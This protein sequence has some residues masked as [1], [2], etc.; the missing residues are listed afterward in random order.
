M[1]N[2]YW[3]GGAGTWDTTT[4]THWSASS[5]GASGA[6]VPTAADSVF[7]D[8]AGTYTV[9]CTGALT[10][11]DF[12][13][14]AG[15][16]TFTNG[17]APTF[18]V[19]GSMSLI[20]GT[21][22]TSTGAIT[23]NST[24]TGKTVTTNGVSLNSAINFNG[25]G[26]GW[27]LGSA[28]TSAATFTVTNGTFSTG[29]YNTSSTTF[30]SSAATTRVINL[31]SSTITVT[32]T[33]T[34]VNIFTTGLTFNAGTSQINVTGS[35]VSGT[36]AGGGA[37]FNNVAYTNAASTG[38]GIQGANTFNTLSFPTNATLGTRTITFS[39]D[40]TISTLTFGASTNATVRTALVSDVV[41]TAR[42][43]TIGS[44]A[45]T[46]VDFRDITVTGAAAPLTGTRLGDLKG[47]SNITFTSKTVYWNLA[48][49]GNWS[50]TAWATTGGG[51][52]NV[53]NFP[54]AQDTAVFQSTGL[55]S[56]A[57]V[58][59]DAAW[60][61]GTID[62]SA[63]TSNTMTLATGTQTPFIYGNW[64]NG[65]GI[66]TTG[67]Q[68]ITF[69]GRTTQTITGAG[70]SLAAPITINTIGGTVQ[71]LDAVANLNIT[72]LTAGTLDLNG[73]ALSSSSFTCGGGTIA[74]GTGNISLTGSG[75]VWSGS[76]VTTIT[77]TPNVYLTYSGAVATTIAAAAAPA[78]NRINFFITAGS[79]ALTVTGS[80]RDINFSNGGTSTYTGDGLT[81]AT[82]FTIGG[83]LT[84][85]SGMTSTGT[86][87]V[88]F[89]S[90]LT[91]TITTAGISFSRS[92]TFNGGGSWQLQDAFTTNAA[93]TLTH[94]VGTIDLNGKTLT[95]GIF[96]ETTG[97]HT[98]A[99]NGG[100]ISL[101]GSGTIF[102]GNTTG[103]ITGT[104][105]VY[106][107]Y[108]GATAVTLNPS[109]PTEANTY[110][111]IVTAGSY[112]LS[113]GVGN[114]K[115]LD[116]S[117]GG[118]S[119]YT[120]AWSGANAVN[121]YSAIILKSGMT[122]TGTGVFTFASTTVTGQLT[123][124]GI[125]SA[126]PIT[127]A[128]GST[129]R[130][131]DAMTLGTAATLT[132]NGTLD[133][134]SKSITA[135]LHSYAATAVVQNTSG[136]LVASGTGAVWTVTVGA[137]FQSIPSV[138]LSDNSATA[139]S[140]AGG[141][142]FTY[143]TLT[144]GGTT[145]TSNTTI[146]NT[147]TFSTLASTKTVAH[148][149]T[150]PSNATTT[151]GTWSVSGTVGNLVT[152][153]PSVAATAYSLYFAG[154][155]SASFLSV[156]Y[157]TA[158][159]G[160][161]YV[162]ALSTNGGGNTN[163]Y[164]ATALPATTYYWVGGS[165]NWDSATTTN[166]ALTSGGAGGA[167]FPTSTDDVVFD[168]NSNVGTTIFTVT[169]T[170]TPRCKSLTFGSGA[171]ALDAVMTLAG[172]VAWNV[173]GSLTFPAT[174]LTRSYTGTLTMSSTTTGNTVTTNGVSLTTASITFGQGALGTGG[175]WTLGSALT[176]STATITVNAGTFDTG[177]YNITH[178]S[179][180]FTSTS[181]L[182]RTIKLNASTYTISSASVP[183]AITNNA[184]LTFDAGTSTISCGFASTSV[185]NGAGLTFYNVTFSSSN[186]ARSVTMT[187]ANT[188]NNLNLSA[189]PATLTT[190]VARFLTLAA[191]ITVNGTFSCN[192]SGGNATIRLGVRSDTYGTTRT[193]TAAAVSL[194]DVD[195]YDIAG[196][197]AA[198]PFTGTR[199]GDAQGNSGITFTSKTIYWNLAAGGNWSATAWATTGGG[200]ADINNFPLAQDTA[201][202]Q[203]T[204]LNSGATVTIEN[205]WYIGA[206]DM[207]ARTS[208]TMTL[209]NGTNAPLVFGDWT[210]GT[211]VT[212][213]G[214]GAIT[215][216]D[217]ATQSITSAGRTFTQSLAVTALTGTTRLLD[218]LNIGTSTLTLNSGTFDA[219]NYNV[220]IGTLSSSNS[221]VRTLAIGSGT[222]TIINTGN[223]WTTT[224]S[225][226]MTV[227]GTGTISMTASAVAKNFSGGSLAYTNITLNQGGPA[228]L[229]ISGSNTFKDI[230]N[231]YG[232]TGATTILFTSGTTQT[233][234]QFTAA[235][236]AGNLLTL[237]AV[238]AG[239]RA[240][241]AYSGAGNPS[242]DYL[243]VQDMAFTPGPATD[244]STPYRWYL[245]ANSTNSGNNTGG[246]F[247]AGGTG[248]IKVYQI[249]N[250]ATTTWTVPADWNAV[251]TIHL[252]GAGGG[253][254]TAIASTNTAAGGGGGGGGYTQLSNFSTVAGASI[255]VAVGAGGAAGLAGGA[256][257]WNAGAYSAGGGG[258]GSATS[259]PSST[260]GTGGVGSTFN[261]G[262]GGAGATAAGI[263]TGAGAGGGGGA[264][265]PNG[266]GGAGGNGFASTTAANVAGGGGGGNGGGSAGGNASSAL[267]GTGGN[268]F[269]GAGG[270][271]S[272]VAGVN[273]GGS[274]GNAGNGSG[275]IAFGGID[276]LNT[277]GGGGGT[278]GASYGTGGGAAATA[279]GS[280]GSGGGATIAG[281]A[282]AGGTGG[283]GVIIIAYLP[284]GATYNSTVPNTATGSDSISAQVTFRSSA[285]ETATGTDATR[286]NTVFISNI[287][288]AGTA[289][290]LISAIKLHLASI[291]ESATGSDSIAA[292]YTARS[293]ITETATATD[294][295]TAK[296]TFLAAVADAAS[297]S[298]V[299]NCG[300]IWLSS[301]SETATAT[302]AIAALKIITAAISEVSTATGVP[303]VAASSFHASI[304]ET[305]S[306]GDAAFAAAVFRA[307]AD[308]SG[309][310]SDVYTV[311][312]NLYPAIVES[313]TGTDETSAKAT[314]VGLA[315]ETA[316]GTDSPSVAPSNFH[317][318]A[319]AAATAT[320]RL[321][322]NATMNSAVVNSAIIQDSLIGGF[323]WNLIDDSQTPDWGA[324][325][326][327]QS[328]TW[329]SVN[330]SQSVAWQNIDNTQSSGWG[331][332][333]DTQ[334]PNWTTIKQ[335][336]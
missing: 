301:I 69:S 328:A 334:A 115:S 19:S 333:N 193:I 221:N 57:T 70:R 118:T 311:K 270:G 209:A 317:A 303:A 135:G 320:D 184:G 160:E 44:S 216:S 274:G 163:V 95:T 22:W 254:A 105:N 136:A 148:T 329:S 81:G 55:N 224:T 208:N 153:A 142:G 319:L 64:I 154:K 72:T 1:A 257:Q 4:T 33:A 235:G 61:I 256:T 321:N 279:F 119:T 155:T 307:L 294:V 54:L 130:L 280:G 67:T 122:S 103:T 258:G 190:P 236:T 143:G 201:I 113:F 277:V 111:F 210:N 189:S 229:T 12:T 38:I 252:F 175:Y 255:T 309:A 266:A 168:V 269:G 35:L 7:F 145:G 3:V 181:T 219:N 161:F 52:P 251:N 247:Q 265:G 116:F 262:A 290:D 298:D 92:F 169:L 241:I 273:G 149:I 313:G 157:C 144:I 129:L 220:T 178:T 43:L 171:Q 323:L 78:A 6:S 15:V 93:S 73:Y 110:N 179:A 305:A 315:L 36:F 227:T 39:A 94:A 322:T 278:G 150:F 62:M 42:T 88:T 261:G 117:N 188:F 132:V 230:T 276:I 90:A 71:I 249:S 5:G 186:A 68:A 134:N 212:L 48:A 87:L 207:S 29:N 232:A 182:T 147:N 211:G 196:A 264:G 283:P 120:G 141:T 108:S 83:S 299:V 187:G 180:T 215:F 80:V 102:T 49:G 203:A 139:R 11:L 325:N 228:S 214:T 200:T 8:Q 176:T 101:S 138:T 174:N 222:W 89:G 107:T 231:S 250:T 185:F 91:N 75:T 146:V 109:T 124:A 59:V 198:A 14:S 233:V 260:G 165:G 248:A 267:G 167:G 314:F 100:N 23:F 128:A 253:G 202:I 297:I 9:T 137:S 191:N 40:Q 85:K 197:G 20:A 199:L 194:Y 271:T 28:L 17:T 77:G 76:T 326:N 121:V 318:V 296:A 127:I 302:D 246:L 152:L 82:A 159:V 223:A 213:S 282:R 51:T 287:N 331:E 56:G 304:I 263:T 123:C 156:S 288:E 172:T 30:V 306:Q 335:N 133:A 327:A 243:N 25:V 204:G 225:T 300:F 206:V 292:K 50:A 24:T 177:G 53:N 244:G 281:L 140:F 66:T 60:N 238:T 332:I 268:N 205:P 98:I 195:F 45:P 289:S 74:F 126:H 21:I 183:L 97:T 37:T 84:M 32:S 286:G 324:V 47:N 27:T 16:V 259:A 330:D 79:Y 86:G 316:T 18:G 34:A 173:F 295:E 151:I 239:T 218:A 13:V 106:L 112:S 58:T 312:N 234:S 245:G 46:D 158:T 308:E 99:F 170:G 26:G 65:T 63:R 217:R 310:A 41:G 291:L 272:G 125:T 166:W 104:P 114:I 240:T 285:T 2:R 31:G 336:P 293:Q 162:G 131:Q 192:G 275:I 96:A 237:D 164:F 284:G 10:C 242:V 226:N